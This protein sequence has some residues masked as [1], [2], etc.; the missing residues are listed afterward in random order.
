MGN[1][2]SAL[3]VVFDTTDWEKA[4]MTK[5]IIYSL[6]RP[7][8]SRKNDTKFTFPHTFDS[9]DIDVVSSFTLVVSGDFAHDSVGI[10]ARLNTEI[11]CDLLW[12]LVF[13]QIRFP[14]SY[15]GFNPQ[16]TL[17][18]R[19]REVLAIAEKRN[20]R[21]EIFKPVRENLASKVTGF[22]P[23]TFSLIVDNYEHI[24]FSVLVNILGRARDDPLLPGMK[25]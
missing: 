20:Q 21:V 23:S 14:T 6:L 16:I 13:N 12:A 11:T 18:E 4:P 19:V 22:Q 1:T 24:P 17:H 8:E 9:E 15:K 2:S 3:S 10:K 7:H 5:R 25:I